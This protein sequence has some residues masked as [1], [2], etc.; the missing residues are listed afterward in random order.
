MHM[1]VCLVNEGFLFVYIS[2]QA[3]GIVE[4]GIV[5]SEIVGIVGRDHG[6]RSLGKREDESWNRVRSRGE[7]VQDVDGSSYR[8]GQWAAAR[9]RALC[10][11][12]RCFGASQVVGEHGAPRVVRELGSTENEGGY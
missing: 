6:V 10:A 2:S 5:E 8:T 3:Y 9:A 4:S 11:P 7:I 12:C 1:L